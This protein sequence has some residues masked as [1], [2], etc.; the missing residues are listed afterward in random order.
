LKHDDT[1]SRSMILSSQGRLLTR[2]APIGAAS[3]A[4]GAA[5]VSKR[6]RK[7]KHIEHSA[8]GGMF[9]KIRH[10]IRKTQRG[11]SIHRIDPTRHHRPG[12]SAYPRKDRYILFAVG[13]PI[14]NRLSDDSGAYLELPQRMAIARVDRFEPAVHGPVKNH[15][16][17][18]GKNSA[19]HREHFPD[20]PDRLG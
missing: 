11:C 8:R 12:P 16:A 3:I 17:R 9:R 14:S 4:Y 10:G 19:P 5:R 13:P 7:R 15:V 1:S 2:A 18:S 6:L 20:F